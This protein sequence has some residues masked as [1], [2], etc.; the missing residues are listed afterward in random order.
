MKAIIIKLFW[1]LVDYFRKPK[2]T[3]G[4]KQ[5]EKDDAEWN[6]LETER[7]DIVDRRLP[8]AISIPDAALFNKLHRRLS[9]IEKRQDYLRPPKR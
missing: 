8:R 2:K 1:I 4:Q 9:A 7:L 5:K 6:K 3:P